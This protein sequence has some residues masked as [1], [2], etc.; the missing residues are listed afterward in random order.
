MISTPEPPL[1]EPVR[2]CSGPTRRDILSQIGAG[3]T[4]LLGLNLLSSRAQADRSAAGKRRQ[5]GAEDLDAQLF[6]AIGSDGAVEITV[7]RSEMGQH[8]WTSM[9][10]IIAD[11][12]EADWQE[13]RVVQAEGHP[14][15]GDQNT[16]GSRSVRRNFDRLRLVG[17]AA[18]HQLERAAAKRWACPPNDCEG[19]LHR[20]RHK[21]SGKTL[22][23]GE[24][25]A[26]A[27]ALDLPK[28]AALVLKAPSQWRYISKDV[29]SLSIPLMTAGAGVFGMDVRRP[30]MLYAVIARPPQVLG[31]VKSV[32]TSRALAV[33]G[34]L[35]VL[36]LPCAR[37]TF[38]VP[39]PGRS[40]GGG[41]G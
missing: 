23:Y 40:G 25:A 30:G 17:A 32:D 27:A 6:V 14:R 2:L 3:G 39:A 13:V 35:Q 31:K 24:L 1:E 12:L 38:G 18:R 20:V 5:A 4:F 21:P 37:G 36:E 7:H 41:Y 16:D 9:A 15:Y 29:S 8:V 26:E 19:I 33:P 11:E 28:E 34:V 22:T 10:Q